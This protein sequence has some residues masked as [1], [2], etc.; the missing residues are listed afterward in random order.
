MNKI[1]DLS[2][3]KEIFK[4]Q[5]WKLIY[6]PNQSL[7]TTPYTFLKTSERNA[8]RML[9][10]KSTLDLCLFLRLSRSEMELML[11]YPN[12]INYSIPKRKKGFRIINAPQGKLNKVQKKI[13]RHLQGVYSCIKH[14]GVHGFV[15]REKYKSQNANIVQNALPHVGKRYLLNLDLK[16]FFSSIPAQKVYKLFRSP[17][18][19]FDE[20]VSEALTYLLTY[21]GVLPQ[22]VATSPVLSNLICLPLDNT[23]S[24]YCE[25]EGITYT[26]YADD[27]SFSS[28]DFITK[29]QVQYLKHILMTHGFSLNDAKFRLRSKNKKQVVTGIIVNEKV[30]VDRKTLKK[31]RAMLH[32]LNTNGIAHA[33]GKSRDDFSISI[34]QRNI[35][36]LDSLTGHV[37]FIGQ[38]R[39]KDDA[40]YQSMFNDLIPWLSY[41]SNALE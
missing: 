14:P 1:E 34:K 3:K 30:N 8:L 29:T 18:F 27:L 9:G 32:D 5:C 6:Y 12:Y 7:R 20:T 16:D 28:D 26:R 13:N 25:Q 15:L 33:S 37:N 23:I 2:I 41:K 24:N 19:G 39:G 22:G 40:L 36:F 35:R 21:N 31:V 38:V 4:D 11:N 17:P 10:I